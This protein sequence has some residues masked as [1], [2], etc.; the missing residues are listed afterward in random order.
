MSYLTMMM[1]TTTMKKQKRENLP[2]PTCSTSSGLASIFVVWW[3]THMLLVRQR[4]LV[5][6][7]EQET[8]LKELAGG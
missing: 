3:L 1:I 6:Q 5:E 2:C 8:R 4:R 7:G